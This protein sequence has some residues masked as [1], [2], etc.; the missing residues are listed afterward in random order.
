MAWSIFSDGGGSGAALTWAQQFLEALGAPLSASNITFVYQW[1]ESEGVG[2][3]YNP[4]NQGTVPGNSALTNSGDQ[5]GGGAANYIS[6]EAGIQGAVD[7]LH[8]SNY[9]G[10]YSA[11]KAGD[12]SQA[13]QALFSSPWASSH[14]GYGSAWSS[15]TPPSSGTALD[16]SGGGVNEVLQPYSPTTNVTA[17]VNPQELAQQYGYAYSMLQAIPELKTLFN[18]A[19]SGQWDATRFQAALLNTKWY[20]DHSAAQRAWAAEGFTD[21]ATQQAQLSSQMQE[22]QLA[23]SKLGA[24]LAPA[25]VKALATDY[26]QDGWNTDQLQHAMTQWIN[27]DANGAL[28]G[29]SGDDEMTL[30]SLAADNGV[31]ISNNWILNVVRHISTETTSLEDAEGYVRQQAEKLFP[32]YSKLIAS[33]QNMSDLAAPYMSDYQKILEVAPGQTSLYD[34]TMIKALQ[35]KDP[36]GENT[37]MPMWQFDQNLRNDPRWLKTQNAQDTTMGVG[38]QILQD[39]GFSF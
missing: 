36:T 38:R 8:M 14:Y 21:P 17:T 29:T 19:V 25:E 23:A 11:L 9:A 26:L 37:T 22:V 31:S 39:F 10:V 2:G 13:Q 20:Q 7:Y 18:Q 1:E 24:N 3:V 6:W 4:L 5:Y 35:Y 33:G 16:S 12:G 27:F 30:R 32:N 34:P 28:G 15:A